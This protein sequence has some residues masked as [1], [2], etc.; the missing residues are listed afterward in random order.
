M[1]RVVD[2]VGYEYQL[3]VLED[4]NGWVGGRV[5]VSMSG[6]F[7]V[8]GENDNG[9]RVVDFCAERELYVGKTYFEH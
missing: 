9:R 6:A 4:L 7:R 5:K 3:C 2:R 8:P 1:G